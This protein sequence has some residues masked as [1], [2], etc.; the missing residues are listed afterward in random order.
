MFIKNKDDV[1]FVNNKY[2]ML[3]D[4]LKDSRYENSDYSVGIRK[5][6]PGDKSIKHTHKSCDEIYYVINGSGKLFVNKEENLLRKG[7][8]ALIPKKT[9]HF[10]KNEGEE[11]MELLVI[12]FV[13]KLYDGWDIWI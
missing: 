5:I 2:D 10:V 11:E 13:G 9:M 3:F 7:D 4:L 8:I 6:K 12:G 1:D